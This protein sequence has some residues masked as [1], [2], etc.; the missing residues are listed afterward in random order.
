V[1]ARPST[2][3]ERG[4]E[5]EWTVSS[6]GRAVGLPVYVPTD[7]PSLTVMS[8]RPCWGASTVK[9]CVADLVERVTRSSSYRL[10]EDLPCG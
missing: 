7:A 9:V 5:P 4:F 6:Y 2:E 3:T 10:K 8:P 1:T